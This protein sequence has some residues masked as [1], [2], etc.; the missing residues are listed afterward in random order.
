MLV[1]I[2]DFFVVLV[3]TATII[4]VIYLGI[5]LVF[6][7]V[8]ID[9]NANMIFVNGI[10][11]L[12]IPPIV[13]TIRSRYREEGEFRSPKVKVILDNGNIITSNC[14][15]MA[16]RMVV[17]VFKIQEEVEHFVFSAY[18]FN[19]QDNKLIQLQPIAYDG[20]NNEISKLKEIK[21]Q[22]LIKPGQMYE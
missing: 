17:S 20:E 15:W 19:I 13:W 16:Y 4:G 2:K 11:W 1:H 5:S 3:G 21:D 7:Q 14:N 12:L 6:D 8:W 22:L 10:Y 18:V 9:T